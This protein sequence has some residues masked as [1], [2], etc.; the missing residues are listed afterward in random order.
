MRSLKI[1]KNRKLR[2]GWM[3]ALA[4]ILALAAPAVALAHPLG[5][6]T[7]N[8]YAGLQV[9][10]DSVAIDFVLDMAEIPAF[11]EISTFDANGNGQP[12]P[13]ETA[14]YTPAKC[15]W[16]RSQL[17]LR[18]EDQPAAIKLDSSAIDFPPGAGGLPTLRLT[19]AFQAPMAQAADAVNISF[20]DNSY[21]DRLGWRE[22]VVTGQ[23]TALAGNIAATSVS[24]RLTAYP[25]DM[26][27]SPLDQ[28]EAAFK[29]DRSAAS[30]QISN[31]ASQ[32]PASDPA[33]S[34]RND[35]FTQ[36]ITLQ[37]VGPLTLLFALAV[38]FIWGALHA[39]S[40]GHGKTVVAAYL[41]GTRGTSRHAILLG[42]TVTL[43]H[44][45]GVFALGFIT[46]FASNYILPEQLYPW[47]SLASGLLVLG[48][49]F[50]LLLTRFRAARSGHWLRP[51]VSRYIEMNDA[52]HD[53][54]EHFH[55]DHHAEH[56]HDHHHG[57]HDHHHDDH[58]HTHPHDHSHTHNPLDEH[59]RISMRSLLAM[60][61]SGGLIPCPTALVV[62]LS[63]IAL[64]R[65]GFGLMLI[66]SFSAGL[67]AVL[68][69]VGLLF[70]HGRRLF[71]RLPLENKLLRWL[72]LTGAGLVIVTGVIMTIQAIGSVGR[73]SL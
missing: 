50:I 45:L 30:S 54:A 73:L 65:V 66:V 37:D 28:R 23:G 42:L 17:E 63:A 56:F 3:A 70:V 64:G 31:P 60:G 72:P 46:L 12:D 36:L 48:I 22:I 9:T 44:T 68:M 47:L 2:L 11:Q 18:I 33:A 49:G 6:F 5:N 57:E 21:S 55:D 71:D 4:M 1:L 52:R 62:L 41:V 25:K 53:Q 43:T 15:D 29:F 40:P 14:A 19:C 10:R 67:A 20:K 8:H 59:N 32:T 27:T 26:L 69:A 34:N 51:D 61:I 39:M 16:I 35:A 38:S 58:G 13:G 7:I 24:N